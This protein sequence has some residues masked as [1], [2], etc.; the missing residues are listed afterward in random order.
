M[1]ARDAG[2]S[3]NA[4][5]HDFA[6]RPRKRIPSIIPRNSGCAIE[7]ARAKEI[8]ASTFDRFQPARMRSARS[9]NVT[10]RPSS[11]Y[12]IAKRA[13]ELSLIIRMRLSI[14][15]SSPNSPA[16][17]CSPINE[18]VKNSSGL[19]LQACRVLCWGETREERPGMRHDRPSQQTVTSLAIAEGSG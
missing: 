4:A 11:R 13:A 15:T 3:G 5:A 7:I 18:S 6:S 16:K 8:N 17:D 9:P 1:K 10:P 19:D 2:S 12:E 14:S